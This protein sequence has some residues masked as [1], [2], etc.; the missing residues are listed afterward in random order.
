MQAKY[1][2]HLKIAPQWLQM[3]QQEGL[4]TLLQDLQVVTEELKQ[5]LQQHATPVDDSQDESLFNDSTQYWDM[6][7]NS[8]ASMKTFL[9]KPHQ[10]VRIANDTDTITVQSAAQNGHSTPQHA[11]SDVMLVIDVVF[12][13]Y[14]QGDMER[15][16]LSRPIIPYT[17]HNRGGKLYALEKRGQPVMVTATG[18][19]TFIPAMAASLDWHDTL[20]TIAKHC[21]VDIMV[22]GH[23][24]SVA[25]CE[26][27]T[28]A[29]LKW[30][31]QRPSVRWL[32]PRMQSKTYNQNAAVITQTGGLSGSAVATDL[33]LHPF[34]RAGIDGTGQ[35]VG[36]G[37]TGVDMN[38]CFFRDSSN[39]FENLEVGHAAPACCLKRRHGQKNFK[40]FFVYVAG[41]YSI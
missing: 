14:R 6:E 19:G 4:E 41:L 15:L 37:D 13:A 30:L 20:Q 33:S 23:S 36:S 26:A 27:D 10:H 3:A 32:S 5:E 28:A 17:L 2:D 40:F 29:V 1:P 38:S 8:D 7:D 16:G 11:S 9:G 34:W 18:N 21:G 31:A 25:V 24:L 39:R 12:P 35:I 22:H